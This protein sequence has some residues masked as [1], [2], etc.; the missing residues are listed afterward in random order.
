MS[1]GGE[2]EVSMFLVIGRVIRSLRFARGMRG[3]WRRVG[4]EVLVCDFDV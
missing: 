3:S 4:I 2:V 1:R